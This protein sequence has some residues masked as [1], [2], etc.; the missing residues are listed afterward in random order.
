MV[1]RFKA[2]ADEHV[3]F[4]QRKAKQVEEYLQQR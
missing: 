1:Q 2:A 4:L 3:P